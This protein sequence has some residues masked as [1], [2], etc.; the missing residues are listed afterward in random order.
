MTI[1]DKATTGLQTAVTILEKWGASS[2][3]GTA[4]LRVPAD[5]YTCARRRDPEWQAYVDEDQLTRISYVLNIH[6]ALRV[7]FDNPNNLYGFMRMT[8]HNEFFNDR[9][10]LEVIA[11]GDI[12][13]LRETW[14]CVNIE[15][16]TIVGNEGSFS[17]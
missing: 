15:R 7:T 6:A 2:E 16:P 3:Q 5:I 9:S 10:P 11:S 8:N 1:K 12:G 13:S 14:L 17:L 4:I